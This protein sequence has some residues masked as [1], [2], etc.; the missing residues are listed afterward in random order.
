MIDEDD[1]ENNEVENETEEHLDDKEECT[2]EEQD[3]GDDENEGDI[4]ESKHLTKR[5]H[6]SACRGRNSRRNSASKGEDNFP[7]VLT[8]FSALLCIFRII[9]ELRIYRFFKTIFF[10][11][12]S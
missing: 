3:G 9:A 4:P 7:G 1:Y 5:R 11:L 8:F 10:L 12:N 2:K 6:S